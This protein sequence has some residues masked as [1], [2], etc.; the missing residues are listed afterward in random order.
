MAANNTE[1]NSFLKL[2][3][4]EQ[5]IIINA[6]D[7]TETLADANDV[8]KSFIAPEFKFWKLDKPVKAS[9]ET[10]V[11]VHELV[12]YANFVQMFGWLESDLDKL[13]FTQHQIKAFCKNHPS[14]LRRNVNST[15][16]L[17]KMDDHFFVVRACGDSDG[18]YLTVE[19]F[20]QEHVWP[21]ENTYHVVIP[22]IAV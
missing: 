15:F 11:Q 14:W 1:N 19:R 2:I 3:S 7:G 13:C 4:V 12:E 21:P 9:E 22:Q 18:L 5:S 17:T 10:A 20:G 8:F 6:C 16:F